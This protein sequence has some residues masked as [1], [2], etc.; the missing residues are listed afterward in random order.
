[1]KSLPSLVTLSLTLLSVSTPV[2]GQQEVQRGRDLAKGQ[3]HG[4]MQRSFL[5]RNEP[6]RTEGKNE[7]SLPREPSP[8]QRPEELK[9]V[10]AQGLVPVQ[11][12]ERLSPEERKQ[13][14]RDINAAGRDIYRRQ[15]PD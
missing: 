13:L 3:S 2:I 9:P 15:R 5:R 14:R 8:A 7:Q 4:E 1:M 6:P 10:P 12:R 11:G